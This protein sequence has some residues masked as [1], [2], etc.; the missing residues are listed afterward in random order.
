M[1]WEPLNWFEN[2]IFPVTIKVNYSTWNKIRTV[3]VYVI[4][5]FEIF[6]PGDCVVDIHN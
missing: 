2:I 5:E 4:F 1:V 3:M 6:E